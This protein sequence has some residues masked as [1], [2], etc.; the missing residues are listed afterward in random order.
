M[1]SGLNIKQFGMRV[2][3]VQA[4]EM[5]GGLSQSGY[6]AAVVACCT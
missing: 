6:S 3:G 1:Q 5:P 4:T 2:E